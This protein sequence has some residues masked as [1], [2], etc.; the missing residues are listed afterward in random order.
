M[1]KRVWSRSRE[2]N[3]VRVC[4]SLCRTSKEHEG[5]LMRVATVGT[6]RRRTAS[7]CLLKGI[8]R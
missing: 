5:N 8:D 4:G 1:E 2:G 3:A 7:S 6:E